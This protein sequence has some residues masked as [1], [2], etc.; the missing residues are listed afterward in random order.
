MS[1][2][3][4]RFGSKRFSST[5]HFAYDAESIFWLL[6]RNTL[7]IPKRLTS[8]ASRSRSAASLCAPPSSACITPLLVVGLHA[9]YGVL[10]RADRGQGD[11]GLVRCLD[12]IGDAVSK[13]ERGGRW[14]TFFLKNLVAGISCA[15][16]ISPGCNIKSRAR[17]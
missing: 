3:L 8:V 6:P 14:V 1:R 4:A 12:L 15:A 16:S 17:W 13:A 11:A 9:S 7:T 5:P 2:F 10:P